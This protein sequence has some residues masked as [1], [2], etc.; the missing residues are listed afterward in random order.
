MP[1]R[2]DLETEKDLHLAL[3]ALIQCG[4]V[5][6]AHDCSEGGLAIALAECC[7]NPAGLLGADV[8]LGNC[9]GSR[10]GCAGDTPAAT[11]TAIALFN[12]AQS[13]IIISCDL[14]SSE[15]VLSELKS[16]SVPHAHIGRVIKD[17]LRISVGGQNYSW[18][19]AELHDLWWNAIRRAV[20]SDSE[21]IP[22]L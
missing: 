19:A 12:E 8:D 6:S 13:R 16:K 15:R 20:E 3:R 10:A 9:G 22:S 1:P 11:D 18:Q 4:D 5:T 21:P 7:F 2:C 14:K 17:D